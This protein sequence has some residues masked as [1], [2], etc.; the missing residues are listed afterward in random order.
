MVSVQL[1]IMSPRV[2]RLALVA[3]SQLRCAALRCAAAGE[4]AGQ[5]SAMKR[6]LL[7]PGLHSNIEYWIGLRPAWPR[8]NHQEHSL[9]DKDGVTRLPQEIQ[10]RLA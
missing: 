2:S 10:L 6:D 1:Y 7:T 3:S 5:S 4:Q 9:R 8:T